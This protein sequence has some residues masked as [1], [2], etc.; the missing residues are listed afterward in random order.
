MEEKHVWIYLSF[1]FLLH[2][3]KHFLKPSATPFHSANLS[4]TPHFSSSEGPDFLLCHI[5]IQTHTD[6]HNWENK[7][8][9]CQQTAVYFNT[10]N[11]GKALENTNTKAD[12]L[13]R[14]FLF[15]FQ[16]LC[17]LICFIA[18]FFPRHFPFWSSSLRHIQCND[19]NLEN[20]KKL[21]KKKKLVWVD[22]VG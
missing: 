14:F 22:K 15:A 19:T 9:P 8:T 11:R 5:H 3:F 6:V 16:S 18:F 20:N 7:E 10:E 21:K 1:T 4:T 17:L 12:D 2:K 13:L